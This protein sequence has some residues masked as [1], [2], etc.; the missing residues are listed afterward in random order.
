M[1]FLPFGQ[2]RK[3]PIV[4]GIV[5]A[6]EN[7]RESTNS[8]SE[9]S[10]STSSS[11]SSD[12]DNIKVNSTVMM[13][14][15]WQVAVSTKIQHVML[16]CDDSTQPQFEGIHFRAACRVRLPRDTAKF[17]SSLSPELGQCQD[18]KSAGIW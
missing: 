16:A 11:S 8:D 3:D 13:D 9:D 1:V 2:I 17:L 4:T 18:A 14:S 7:Q 10:S 15:Q 12:S 5:S 6:L